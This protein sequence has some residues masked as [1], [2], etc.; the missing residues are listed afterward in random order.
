M[1]VNK[2]VRNILG[3]DIGGTK[4]SLVYGNENGEVF[5]VVTIPTLTR[6]GFKKSFNNILRNTEDFI[7]RLLFRNIK[8]SCISVSIGGP[9]DIENGVI[10][11]PPNLKN[12]DKIPLK[13]LLEK[14][15]RIPAFIEHD[16]NAGALAEYYFGAGKGYKNIIFL[17]MGT[18]IGA[19]IILNGS[20]YRGT[21]DMAG[22][23]GHIRIAEDGPLAYGKK[24]SFESYCSGSGIS[25]LARML[26]PQKYGKKVT[27]KDIIRDIK[28]GDKEAK[29]IIS[30][31]SK[32]LGRGLSIL[33]DILNPE[34]I[35]IGSLAVRLGDVLLFPAILEMKRESL[36]RSVSVCHVV[37]SQLGER[38]GEVASL[39]AGIQKLKN[40]RADL[41]QFK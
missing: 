11:S 3:F 28:N 36:K 6:S 23:I 27:A 4:T 18:G 7:K 2:R 1:R 9:I 5:E 40:T 31:T 25:K 19:G 30:I 34:I 21:N 8:F 12:W 37:P 29:E 33:V 32:Y 22:E 38:I 24:G 13:R 14:K 41:R 17:T 39:C 26:F 10:Y 16:G 20:V 35:I 15:F